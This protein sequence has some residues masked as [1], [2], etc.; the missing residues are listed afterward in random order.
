[1]TNLPGEGQAPQPQIDPTTTRAELLARSGEISAELGELALKMAKLTGELSA[2]NAQLIEQPEGNTETTIVP[3]DTP[4]ELFSAI[5]RQAERPQ[6]E[7]E[8]IASK[9]HAFP[10]KLQ[11]IFARSRM[12]FNGELLLREQ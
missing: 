1:M 9:N 7:L 6:E 4:V 5:G 2:I 10:E 11:D 8:T 3:D 12:M